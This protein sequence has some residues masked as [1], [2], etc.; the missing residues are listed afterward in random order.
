MLGSYHVGKKA[1][2]LY[3]ISNWS[4]TLFAVRGDAPIK[5]FSGYTE[6]L[7]GDSVIVINRKGINPF[8]RAFKVVYPATSE[9]FP[10]YTIENAKCKF[11]T[12]DG[13]FIAFDADTVTKVA[14][15]VYALENKNGIQWINI[16]TLELTEPSLYKDLRP[17]R[18]NNFIGKDSLGRKVILD[19]RLK[20]L[21]TF[22]ED[23]QPEFGRYFIVKTGNKTGM[24]DSKGN[25]IIP[26][27]SYDE[28]F[29]YRDKWVIIV[30]KSGKTSLFDLATRL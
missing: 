11:F 8:G 26:F 1:D 19:T 20:E 29:T 10:F 5:V 15:G 23:I 7:I 13:N 27:E 22:Y 2:S 16:N 6:V 17:V 12:H 30:K 28:P 18:L 25:V 9:R 3:F 24:L 4:D 14:M 21:S